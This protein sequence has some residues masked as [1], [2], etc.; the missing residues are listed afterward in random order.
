[1]GTIPK[2]SMA[3]FMLN[4]RLTGHMISADA[5]DVLHPFVDL[6]IIAHNYGCHRVRSPLNLRFKKLAALISAKW[7]S[8]WG[9]LPK[10]LPCLSNSSA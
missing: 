5:A 6:A 2:G 9:V 7:L 10:C 1:M 4:R 8:A 3:G